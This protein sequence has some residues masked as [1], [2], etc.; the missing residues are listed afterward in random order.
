M[1]TPRAA[2]A[3]DPLVSCLMVSRGKLFP[4]EMAIACYLGQTYQNRELIIV[5]ASPDNEI[6]EHVE[7]LKNPS[8][9]FISVPPAPL[10]ELRNATVAASR[11]S[12]LCTWDDD[13]LYGNRRI[14]QQ[15]R[16]YRDTGAS[17][18]FLRRLTLWWPE[19][20]LIGITGQGQWEGSMMVE[21]DALPEYSS[22]PFREDTE[23]ARKI[24]S[25]REIATFDDPISYCY[26]IHSDNACDVSHFEGLF[27]KASW[28]FDDYDDQLT[29]LSAWY[30]IKRYAALLRAKADAASGEVATQGGRARILFEGR[31]YAGERVKVDGVHFRNCSFAGATIV[32]LGGLAPVFEDCDMAGFKVVFGGS[33]LNTA[34]FMKY[35]KSMGLGLKG[36]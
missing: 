11:G 36:M 34:N 7:R 30:P 10:G 21:R 33:A 29:R 25:E 9:K 20:R 32:Y 16:K 18:I 3:K 5:S 1:A 24:R 22:L 13:D 26:V 15:V 35:L 27:Q 4:A 12:L 23:V 17:A 8:I 19:R 28:I 6:A 2:S 31:S 14:E